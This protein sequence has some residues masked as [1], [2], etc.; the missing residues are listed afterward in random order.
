MHRVRKGHALTEKVI[1]EVAAWHARPLKRVYAA[2]FVD[3]LHVRIRGGRVGPRTV[4]AAV[5]VV[6]AGNP[7]RARDVRRCGPRGVGRLL[8]V[9]AHPAQAPRSGRHLLPGLRGLKGVPQSVGTAFPDTEVQTYVI[10][11]IRGK[12]RDATAKAINLMYTAVSSDAAAAA[13]DAFDA[14]WG[15]RSSAAI[16]L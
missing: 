4:Y 2:A 6:L 7:R 10:Y 1:E 15:S 13:I 11:L 16:R 3:A 8:A 12:S 9:G 14:E 5:G